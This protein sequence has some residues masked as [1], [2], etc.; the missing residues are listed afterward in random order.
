[1][2]G[3]LMFRPV[4]N[5]R[6]ALEPREVEAA[7]RPAIVGAP[8]TA[9]I[10]MENTHNREGGVALMPEQQDAI[11]NLARKHGIATHL[12]GARIFNASVAL[13]IPV[14]RLTST[15]T[16]MMFCLSK[17]LAA[18]VGSVVCGS[19][20]FIEEARCYRRMLG[21]GMRQAGILAA[22]GIVALTQMVGRL[23]EDHSCARLLAE[24]IAD[25]PGLSID[26]STVQT[27]IVV[28][29]IARPDMTAMDFQERLAAAGVKVME[30][31]GTSWLRAC[32]H[33]GIV[34]EDIDY[35]A[36]VIRQ[37]MAG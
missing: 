28:F 6:G 36:Q 30:Y 37:V 7:I 21:G 19:K 29:Q 24:V 15:F 23:S 2:V 20:A 17:G 10:C 25:T 22:A 11:I 33:Y 35:A 12:D 8:R 34:R 14:S 32:T 5:H 3:S 13:G 31:T 9:L 4:P 1:M 27:N 16:S 18:P 26:L